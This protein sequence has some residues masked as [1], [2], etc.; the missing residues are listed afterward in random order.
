M[1]E[2][3]HDI[4]IIGVIWHK[5]ITCLENELDGEKLPERSKSER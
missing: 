4:T 1:V 5:Q 2:F 3:F